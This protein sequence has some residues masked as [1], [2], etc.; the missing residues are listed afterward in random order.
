MDLPIPQVKIQ[1]IKALIQFLE[2]QQTQ[3]HQTVVVLVHLEVLLYQMVMVDLVVDLIL[4]QVLHLVDLEIVLQQVHHKV[5]QVVNQ[6]QT[7]KHLL[8]NLRLV[9]VEEELVVLVAMLIV[10]HPQ[11]EQEELEEMEVQL[12]QLLDVHLNLFMDQQME[13]MQVVVVAEQDLALE[14]TELEDQVEEQQ[15]L[16]LVT[17]QMQELILEEDLEAQFIILEM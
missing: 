11:R 15:V 5:I 13:Y 1:V 16:I 2:T 3:L 10:L 12:L 9:V 4:T 6:I 17:H 14:L 7:V 8:D